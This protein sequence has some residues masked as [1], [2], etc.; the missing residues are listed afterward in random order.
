M[1]LFEAINNL[2]K[3]AHNCGNIW[4]GLLLTINKNDKYFSKFYYEDTPLLD[5]NDEELD[6][7]MNDL[8]S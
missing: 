1:E 6:E 4:C 2:Y 3:E 8:K 7:R 5:G